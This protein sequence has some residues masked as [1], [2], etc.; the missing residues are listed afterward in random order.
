MINFVDKDGTPHSAS[1]LGR[2]AHPQWCGDPAIPRAYTNKVLEGFPQ[3]GPD[4][5][6]FTVPESGTY[7][8]SAGCP[9]TG[10]RGCGSG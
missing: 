5:M 1:D 4:V 9:A 6:Q 2:R 10:C 8:I 3:G 7:R